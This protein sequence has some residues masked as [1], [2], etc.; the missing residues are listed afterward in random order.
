MKTKPTIR[1]IANAAGVTPAT[2][3]YVLN[4]NARQ[5]ISA[6]TRERVLAAAREM[7]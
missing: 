1:D 6:Q 7:G 3:S 5:A 4:Q 2:V